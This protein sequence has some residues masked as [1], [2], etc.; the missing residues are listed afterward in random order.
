MIFERLITLCLVAIILFS[1]LFRAALPIWAITPVYLILLVTLAIW[2]VRIREDR[3]FSFTRTPLDLPILFFILFASLSLIR[4]INIHH[5]ISALYRL[6][7]YFLIY[8][9]VVNNIKNK[10]EIKKLILSIL[11]V[12]VFVTLY[13]LI[14]FFIHNFSPPFSTFP[15]LNIFASFLLISFSLASGL[16]LFGKERGRAKR[17]VLG[18]MFILFLLAIITTRSRGVFLSLTLIVTF[19]GYLKNKRYA[20]I[21]LVLVILFFSLLPTPA[22]SPLVRLITVGGKDPYAYTRLSIW[23]SA[24]SIFK[25]HP[26]LGTGLGTFQD[27]FPGY[28]FP[29]EGVF[30]RFGKKASFAHNEYLQIASE[31]GIFALGIFMWILCAFLKKAKELLRNL[32]GKEEYGLVIGLIVGIM[33]ILIHSLVDFP[34]HAP[35][36]TIFLTINAGLLMGWSSSPIIY[37]AR[38]VRCLLSNG[39]KGRSRSN[40]AVHRSFTPLEGDLSRRLVLREASLM[41]PITTLG[42]RYYLYSVLIILILGYAVIAPYL[43]DIYAE[44][45]KYRKAIAHDPLC[46]EYHFKLA[47]L[48]VKQYRETKDSYYRIDAYKE[49]K[50]AIR[51]ESRNGYYHRCLAKF[52]HENFTGR[53]RI[54]FAIRAMKKALELSPY[55]C[56]FHYELGSI[57]ANEERY[58]ETIQNY[59]KAIELEPNY[60]QAHYNLGRIYEDLDNAELAE[61]EYKKAEESRRKGLT[62]LTRTK[63]E[64][65]LI[66]LQKKRSLKK[67]S[68]PSDF[69]DFLVDN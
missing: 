22:N 36:V 27:A 33:G 29:V 5:S 17:I 31:M 8:F 7:S 61:E 34:L 41:G 37:P 15:N 28:S 52:Y 43:A 1:P 16:L 53:S 12:S 38:P 6:I 26:F 18:I 32:R 50:R 44:R 30:A 21:T 42:K 66:S 54:D 13:G 19:L 35:A 51:L 55:D 10:L 48:Y 9:L 67:V 47:N 3:E 63:Y 25:N 68:E 58:E 2:L 64:D 4:S 14:E 46:G 45:G 40:G 56:F 20:L 49:F 60:V 39:V 59:K 23:K 24:L 62:K 11:G 69:T 57:Y 65:Q